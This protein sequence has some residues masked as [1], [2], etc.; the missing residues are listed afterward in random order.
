[1]AGRPEFKIRFG[2][3]VLMAL[4]AQLVVIYVGFGDAAVL[5][6]FIFPSTYVLLLAFVILNRRRIGFLVIGAGML[7]NFLAIVSN[8]GLMPVTPANVEKAGM[9]YKIEGV[10]LGEAIPRSMNVLLEESDTNLQWLSDR[11]TWGSPGP[12]SV[13]SIG[14]VIIGAG[15]IIVLVELLLPTLLRSSPDRTSPT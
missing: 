14:D 2:W 15:L 5:R 6:R 13:F 7:L 9:G 3:L 12:F 4:A 1:M 10:E 11:F 8:G